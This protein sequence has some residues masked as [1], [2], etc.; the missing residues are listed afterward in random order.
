V[1]LAEADH[2]EVLDLSDP[3]NPVSVGATP[4]PGSHSGM[5]RPLVLYAS[6]AGVATEYDY[7]LDQPDLRPRIV[8]LS[9]PSEPYEWAI[10]DTPGTAESISFGPGVVV[11]A[12]GA[13][14]YS[15]FESCIPF[16]D[17]FETGDTSE[18]SLLAP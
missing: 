18:W 11:V 6:R 5:Q 10:L 15:V 4:L 16:A 2:L 12:D 13:A 8:E 9:S 3:A 17:G 14:G 1:V 7:V